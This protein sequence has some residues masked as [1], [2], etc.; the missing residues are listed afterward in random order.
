M[1]P[2]FFPPSEETARALKLERCMRMLPQ[3]QDTGG[4]FVAVLVK[5]GPILWQ[6]SERP[7]DTQG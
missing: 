7:R 6:V 4:F 5:T 3:D 1:I 2:S